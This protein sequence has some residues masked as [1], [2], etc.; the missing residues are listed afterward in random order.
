[1]VEF[2][3]ENR[4]NVLVDARDYCRGALKLGC[5]QNQDLELGRRAHRRRYRLAGDQRHLTERPAWS[6]A[7]DVVLDPVSV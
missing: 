7:I 1:V 6:N 3:R 4:G 5:A 2:A